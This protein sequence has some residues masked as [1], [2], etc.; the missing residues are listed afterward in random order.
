[1]NMQIEKW[2]RAASDTRKQKWISDASGQIHTIGDLLPG[3]DGAPRDNHNLLLHWVDQARAAVATVGGKL[4]RRTGAALIHADHARVAVWIAAVIDVA[5]NV[6]AD[7]GVDDRVCAFLGLN[8]EDCSRLRRIESETKWPD[9]IDTTVLAE[10]APAK[11]GASTAS[12]DHVKRQARTIVQAK[13][14][15]RANARA[16]VA[17]FAHVGHTLPNH[18]AD[19]LDDDLLGVV[20]NKRRTQTYICADSDTT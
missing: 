5:R 4:R 19:V 9:N 11:E 14:V 2:M 3:L 8:G 6:A 18:L 16:L 10:W 7:G 15:A 1:M 12:R 17:A 13:H 20:K